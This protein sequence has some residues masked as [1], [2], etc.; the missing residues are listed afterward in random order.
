MRVVVAGTRA[1]AAPHS[2]LTRPISIPVGIFLGR[3][4]LCAVHVHNR[5]L[6][7]RFAASVCE[8]EAVQEKHGSLGDGLIECHRLQS[9]RAEAFPTTKIA[10]FDQRLNLFR[11]SS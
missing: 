5:S 9:P 6:A 10:P 2:R 7:V 3:R 4:R 11:S 8:L 1:F